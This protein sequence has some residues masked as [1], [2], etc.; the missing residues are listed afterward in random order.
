MRPFPLNW[1]NTW[2]EAKTAADRISG[3]GIFI[4]EL[5]RKG[6]SHIRLK[7]NL[8]LERAMYSSIILGN[9]ISAF[10]EQLN[11]WTA[12]LIEKPEDRFAGIYRNVWDGFLAVYKKWVSES[13]VLEEEELF[14]ELPVKNFWECSFL[15]PEKRDSCMYDKDIL[16]C[17]QPS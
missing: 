4:T 3:T 13:D 17:V 1:E 6:M 14:S 11:L 12:A 9:I 2:E 5:Y 7:E 16:F 8:K 15:F 10:E